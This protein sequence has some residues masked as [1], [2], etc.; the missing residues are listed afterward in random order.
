MPQPGLC[1]HGATATDI[2]ML[3]LAADGTLAITSTGS[4]GPALGGMPS[5][6]GALL[7]GN[8]NGT[9]VPIRVSADGTLITA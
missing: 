7:Y 3:K 8:Y 5:P 6:A 1:A 9:L 4:G 2:V